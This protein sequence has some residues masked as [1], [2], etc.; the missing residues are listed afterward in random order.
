MLELR[1]STVIFALEYP[2]RT[3]QQRPV[4]AAKTRPNLIRAYTEKKLFLALR[5]SIN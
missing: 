4:G 2:A 1:A 5:E 3:L